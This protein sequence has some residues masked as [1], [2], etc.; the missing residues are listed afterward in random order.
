[1]KMKKPFRKGTKV[2][3]FTRK[4]RGRH[5]QTINLFTRATVAHKKDHVNK[6][7][8]K[9]LGKRISRK[10]TIEDIYLI[11]EHGRGFHNAKK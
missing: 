4:I 11:C 5:R 6:D 2:E 9:M 8:L 7:Q 10:R 1:M 3:I